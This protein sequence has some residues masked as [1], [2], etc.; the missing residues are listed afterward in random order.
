MAASNWDQGFW[1]GILRE[2]DGTPSF[3]RA[4]TGG[5]V[6]SILAWVTYV[7]LKTHAIP[8]LAGPASFLTTATL[9]LYGLNKGLTSVKNVFGQ[10]TGNG[11]APPQA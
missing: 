1:K 4:A 7:V 10:F 9:S 5:V 3:S 2:E 8:D 6:F 11:G